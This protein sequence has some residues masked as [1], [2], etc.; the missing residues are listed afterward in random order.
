MLAVVVC[1]MLKIIVWFWVDFANSSSTSFETQ[2][3]EFQRNKNMKN[4]YHQSFTALQRLFKYYLGR[5]E[6]RHRDGKKYLL[7]LV[8]PISAQPPEALLKLH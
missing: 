3:I 2:I 8:I 7:G 5:E 1:V 6:H 4:I